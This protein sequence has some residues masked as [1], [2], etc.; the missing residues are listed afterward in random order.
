MPGGFEAWHATLALT[1]RP[2][3]VFA[4]VIEV[5]TLPM[6]HPGQELAL[7]RAVAL[8]LIGDDDAWHV[9]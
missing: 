2:M 5:A 6:F 3:R 9:L 8:E 7:G 1:R 4:A